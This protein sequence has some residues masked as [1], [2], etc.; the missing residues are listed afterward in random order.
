MR[1]YKVKI[2]NCKF[3]FDGKVFWWISL[4]FSAP[5]RPNDRSSHQPVILHLSSRTHYDNIWDLCQS[6]IVHVSRRK[7]LVEVQ[8]SDWCFWDCYY[9]YL[10]WIQYS[11]LQHKSC[12][13]M[14]LWFELLTSTIER[15][16]PEGAQWDGDI[17]NSEWPLIT[18]LLLSV[19]YCR[20]GE[21][22]GPRFVSSQDLLEAVHQLVS[23]KIVYFH[24]SF[25]LR[26]TLTHSC[27]GIYFTALFH[28]KPDLYLF[29]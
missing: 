27:S 26:S 21:L 6:C 25:S 20:I 12:T 11:F 10:S 13:G 2:R 19:S 4:A 3:S 9:F 15:K 8:Y 29:V 28:W 7:L 1:D 23:E 22:H 14:L 18:E 24:L 17:T 16:M 5:H